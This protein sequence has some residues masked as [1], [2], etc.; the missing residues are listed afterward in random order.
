MGRGRPR[1]RLDDGGVGDVSV[2]HCGI[3]HVT[4]AGVHTRSAEAFA[5]WGEGRPRGVSIVG[6]P[7]F[8]S[9]KVI[10]LEVTETPRAS[11]MPVPVAVL[12]VT[13]RQAE[14]ASQ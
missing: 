9:S 7:R 11:H 6:L 2:T 8:S 3:R 4:P 14:E 1:L 10:I 12:R 13:S 5:A